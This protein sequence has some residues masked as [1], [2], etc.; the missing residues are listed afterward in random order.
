MCQERRACILLGAE[1]KNDGFQDYP[2][3]FHVLAKE[4]SLPESSDQDGNKHS[5]TS[6]S[7]RRVRK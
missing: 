7:P 6:C 4:S 2:H 1:I 3:S 5:P